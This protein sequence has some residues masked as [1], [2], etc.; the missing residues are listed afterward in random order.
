MKPELAAHGGLFILKAFTKLYG[1]AGVRLGYGLCADAALLERMRARGSAVGGFLSGAG[2]GAGGADTA[3][4][5]SAGAR[6]DRDGK[7]VSA[8]GASGA[9]AAA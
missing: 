6:A 8:G 2:G 9:G 7:T 4:L 3:G 5:R 1:M